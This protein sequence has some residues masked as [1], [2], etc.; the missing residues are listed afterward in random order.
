MNAL[1]IA[2][3]LLEAPEDDSAQEI[4]RYAGQVIPRV[5]R[6]YTAAELRQMTNNGE[7]YIDVNVGIGLWDLIEHDLEWVNDTVGEQIAGS[8]VAL[9]DIGYTP[10]GVVGDEVIINVVAS[11]AD[12]LADAGEV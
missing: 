7:N 2:K 6:P 11:V 1:Q 3:R 12:W 9:T 8:V 4:N 5:T 10:V